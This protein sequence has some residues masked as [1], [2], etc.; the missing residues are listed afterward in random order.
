MLSWM[1]Y[2][3]FFFLKVRGGEGVTPASHYPPQLFDRRGQWGRGDEPPSP[4]SQRLEG[5]LTPLYSRTLHGAIVDDVLFN[6]LE[7]LGFEK[8]YCI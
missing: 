3:S 6:M 1:E 2:L 8:S 4:K 5:G 7:H